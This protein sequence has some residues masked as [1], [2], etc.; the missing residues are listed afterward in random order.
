MYTTNNDN[1]ASYLGFPI[2]F[3]ILSIGWTIW[4][5]FDFKNKKLNTKQTIIWLSLNI[6]ALSISLYSIII[7]IVSIVDKNLNPAFN[8][9]EYLSLH[10][11]GISGRFIWVFWVVIFISIISLNV[12]IKVS[13]KLSELN[14]KIDDLNVSLAITKGKLYQQHEDEEKSS[15]MSEISLEE[16]KK[17]IDNKLE[18]EKLRLKAEKKL[19]IYKERYNANK[20]KNYLMLSLTEEEL[21]NDGE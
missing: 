14:K 18:K 20:R 3:L 5:T 7:G 9:I 10:I 1:I 16:Y 6:I 19:D 11:F 12:A 8:F 21:N 2:L 15:I 4:F 13:V 17:L